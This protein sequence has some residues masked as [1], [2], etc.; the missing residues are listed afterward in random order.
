[1]VARKTGPEFRVQEEGE[2]GDMVDENMKYE[3]QHVDVDVDVDE[4][5]REG[6]GDGGMVWELVGSSFVNNSGCLECDKSDQV[7]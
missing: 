5:R 7:H 2:K 3:A 6:N 1:M 4:G